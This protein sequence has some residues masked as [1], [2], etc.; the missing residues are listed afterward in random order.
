MHTDCTVSA[1]EAG[2]DAR[3]PAIRSDASR[4]PSY[5]DQLASERNVDS[6]PFSFPE[7]QLNFPL[8]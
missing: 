8:E 4:H 7:F 5:P 3:A 1:G 2:T 6:N